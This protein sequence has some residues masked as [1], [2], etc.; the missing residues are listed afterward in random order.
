MKL[1]LMLMAAALVAA[2][3]I[4]G[5]QN[6]FGG[7][8][9]QLPQQ[10][11]QPQP[12]GG[13]YPSQ[14]PPG[15]GGWGS[16]PQQP[17]QGPGANLD[18]LM[19][20]E[21]QEFGI[22]PTREL[23]GGQMHEPTPASIPGG[24]IITTK[25]LVALIQGRQ[26]P[27]YLFDVLGGPE[28][29]PGAMAAVWVGQPGS[30]RD[31]VQQQFAQMLQ[32]GT[33]GRKDTVLIF[34]CLSNQCWMSYN[35]ALRAINAGF[36]NVLWY[37]GG[38]EAWKAAGFPTQPAQQGYPQQQ[39]AGYPQQPGGYPQQPGGYPQQPGGYPQQPQP[40]GYPQQPQPGGYP[41]Q[42]PPQSSWPQR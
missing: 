27:Y 39:P 37:R 6:S 41:Q 32:Q 28:M 33:G 31:Q 30:F 4:V 17:Q 16:Q 9:Q 15:Q 13:G 10:P 24:Q 18:Q 12:A 5:A 8:G 34:Y 26:A 22:Q 19:Q 29:L 14:P 1:Q 36:T 2:P 3:A 25:G 23:H 11:Q 20:V 40:G 7:Q 21:R 42:P 35:A 38:I